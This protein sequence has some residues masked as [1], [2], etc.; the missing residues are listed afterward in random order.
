MRTLT[1]NWF[2]PIWILGGTILCV[3]GLVDWWVFGL[4]ALAD[5]KL[6]TT[7]RW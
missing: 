2:A 6:T 4:I 7:I 5:V 3:V 1:F